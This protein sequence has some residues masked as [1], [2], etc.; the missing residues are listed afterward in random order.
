MM[1]LNRLVSGPVAA[2]V[3]MLLLSGC[4]MFGKKDEEIKPMELE[5][6]ESGLNVKRIWSR[7]VGDGPGEAGSGLQPVFADGAIW[8]A[9]RRGRIEALDPQD[10]RRQ[11]LIE[12]DLRLSAGPA[13]FDETLA[14]GTI[15]GQAVMLDRASGSVLWRAQLSSEILAAP[16]LRDG[17]LI[18]RC[19]DGRVFGLNADDGR[20]IWVFDRS[21]PLLTLRGTSAPL[22]RGGQVFIGH[23]D[24][25]VTALDVSQ[26][27][28]LWEQQISSP[29]GRSELDRLADIDGPMAI[30]GLDLY[31]VTRHGRMASIALDSGRLLWVKDL[32]SHSGLSVSRT[33]LASSDTRDR[34]WMLDRRSGST[35]WTNEKLLRR[36]LTRP[37][38]QGNFVVV[39]DRDGY[40]H[41]LSA[42]TG[43]FVARERA[44]RDAPAAAPLVV[45]NTVFM[46]DQDG[47]M[48]AWRIGSSG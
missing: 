22:L 36:H 6:I 3:A 13:V 19:I 17:I 18:V 11:Q 48:S 34:V 21:V 24:G 4:G 25:A 10:G 28:R 2:L 27:E 26:G 44:S 14:V 35:L 8:V 30:V 37:V 42:E 7:S 41:W 23:D 45:E 1:R 31:A 20:R 39:G 5:S 43:E 15:N 46:I 33:Q 38:F 47:K 12:V 16:L 9:D 32:A 29:E 40:L